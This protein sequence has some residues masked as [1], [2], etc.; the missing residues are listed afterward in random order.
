M[1]VSADERPGRTKLRFWA[2]VAL[3]GLVFVVLWS[4]TLGATPT[5]DE[6]IY[7][8]VAEHPLESSFYPGE[9]FLRHPPLGLALLSAWTTIGLAA[10]AWPLVWTLGAIGLLGDAA[11]RREASPVPV[12]AVTLAA[13]V[14]VPLTTVTLYPPLFFFLTL[15]AWG[16]SAGRRDVEIVAWN[17]AV[18]T[19]EL[20]LLVLAAFLAA[21]GVQLLRERSRDL[22][23]WA[24][25][26]WPYPAAVV[27]GLVMLVNLG[28]QDG[29]GD[30]LATIL[31]PSPN[32]ASIMRMT[33]WVGLV[34]LVT[35]L[36]MMPDP[37]EESSASDRGLWAASLGA[38]IAAP[39]YRY[40]L[41]IAA[42]LAGRGTDAPSLGPSW[43]AI[44]GALLAT[45]M[46][47]GP[48]L[49]GHD[50]LNA[51]N[52]P[53]LVDHDEASQLI[54]PNETVVVRST[55]SFAHALAPEGWTIAATAD[56]GPA[57]VEL[58]R[59]EERIVLHRAETYGRMHEVGPV[60]AVVFPSSW[61]SVADQLPGRWEPVAERGS[62]T[63]WE[64][65]TR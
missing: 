39:F 52:M 20:A 7:L 17:L 41:P 34:I 10:R 43:A 44:A 9:T 35:I 26:V 62:A 55:P 11:R 22:R 18:F 33:A 3:A 6:V 12:L 60:D 15:A 32:V 29:R 19:H 13:P 65:V 57:T 5:H 49:T 51:A 47:M 64:P 45:G 50:T 27:W 23:A 53:G 58:T 25:L 16:W 1:T 38:A 24:R 54:G 31:D 2:I 37:R 36:A 59:F 46:M 4:S 28:G 30:Y 48:T 8:D 42:I 21:R 56:T 61:T 63:R 14:V 40:V